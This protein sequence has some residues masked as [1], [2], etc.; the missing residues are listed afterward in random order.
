MVPPATSM[1]SKV[2]ESPSGSMLGREIATEVSSRTFVIFQP[3]SGSR[4]LQLEMVMVAGTLSSMPSLAM[5]LNVS[6]ARDPKT[7]SYHIPQLGPSGPHCCQGPL[8]VP[9]DGGVM[10]M[11]MVCGGW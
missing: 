1:T 6:I 7:G 10:L 11:V 5:I 8:M 2:R 4:L 3:A 9:C